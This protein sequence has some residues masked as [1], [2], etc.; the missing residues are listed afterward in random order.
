MGPFW[1]PQNQEASLAQ[2]TLC[3]STI[4]HTHGHSV[5]LPNLQQG[6]LLKVLALLSV[7]FSGTLIGLLMAPTPNSVKWGRPEALATCWPGQ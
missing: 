1:S 3:T 7:P 6:F 5:P 2:H 4:T